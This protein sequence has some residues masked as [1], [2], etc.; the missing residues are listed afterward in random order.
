MGG[1][2][3]RAA[4]I[5]VVEDDALTRTILNDC[6]EEGGYL[7]SEAGTCLEMDAVLATEVLDLIVLDIGLPDDDGLRALEK[8]E[9]P[10]PPV[11]CVTA[12]DMSEDRFRSPDSRVSKSYLPT[13]FLSIR[14]GDVSI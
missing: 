7:V 9:A 11:I 14:R 1:A 13:R 4:R 10:L 2:S 3:G 5:L 6:L 12:S 8:N